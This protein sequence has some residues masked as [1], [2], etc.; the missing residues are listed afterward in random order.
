MIRY[1]KQRFQSFKWAFK[2]LYLLFRRHPNAQ[3][4]LFAAII[5]A[6]LGFYLGLSR[7]EW[8]VLLL[9]I[10]SVI[11]LEALNSSLEALCDRVSTEQHPLI[12]Q[13]KDLAAAA[14]LWAAI[15][16]LIIGSLLFIP[17]LYT[18]FI[19]NS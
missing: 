18:L 14:V 9:C 13:A 15:I 3:V 19:M 16:A 17:K 12:G 1:L 5:A 8:M 11:S 10:S 7:L 4:H 6:A 2:G